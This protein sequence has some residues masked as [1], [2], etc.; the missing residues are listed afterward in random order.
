MGGQFN[1]AVFKGNETSVRKDFR[2]WVNEDR[3]ENGHG[4]YSGGIGMKEGLEFVN[5]TPFKNAGQAEDWLSNNNSKWE[6]AQAVPFITDTKEA[7]ASVNKRKRLVADEKKYREA[8]EKLERQF[9]SEITGI[10]SAFKS[11]KKCTSKIAKKYL[12]RECPVCNSDMYSETQ[13]KRLAVAGKK[14]ANAERSL[15]HF[16]PKYVGGKGKAWV[17]GGWCSC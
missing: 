8:F 5:I 9:L 6:S 17:V 14:F 13:E 4:P 15:R 12:K 10:K 2:D 1:S 16:E 7:S 3:H 11:C